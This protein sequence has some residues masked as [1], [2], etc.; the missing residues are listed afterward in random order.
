MRCEKIAEKPPISKKQ[1]AGNI[2]FEGHLWIQIFAHGCD[3]LLT[4][5]VIKWGFREIATELPSG[6]ADPYYTD[7][8]ACPEVVLQITFFYST[9]TSIYNI[10]LHILHTK[11][12]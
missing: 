4:Q 9:Y 2:K 3:L 5:K 6:Q 12:K 8:K 1:N 10:P 11:A 7:N